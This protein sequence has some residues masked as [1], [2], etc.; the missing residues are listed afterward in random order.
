MV[1]PFARFHGPQPRFGIFFYR[2]PI[3]V[4]CGMQV[5]KFLVTQAQPLAEISAIQRLVAICH[6]QINFDRIRNI[7]ICDK[8][9]RYTL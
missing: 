8:L 1:E 4:F 3:P 9:L 7:F 5:A 6:E 2:S